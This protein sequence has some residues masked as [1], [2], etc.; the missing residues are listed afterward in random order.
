MTNTLLYIKEYQK[1]RRYQ[2]SIVLQSITSLPPSFSKLKLKTF[3]FLFF[4]LPSGYSYQAYGALWY[5]YTG[6]HVSKMRTA[7][8]LFP[9]IDYSHEKEPHWE[10]RYTIPSLWEFL[11]PRIKLK[12]INANVFVLIRFSFTWHW[13]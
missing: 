12:Q 1:V 9:L 2:F 11:K 5:P 7:M 3:H 13:N 8:I 6:E 10:G 4:T